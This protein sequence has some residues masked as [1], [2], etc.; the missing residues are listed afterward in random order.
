MLLVLTKEYIFA[1]H[2]FALMNCFRN[3]LLFGFLAIISTPL[4]AFSQLIPFEEGGKWGFMDETGNILVAAEYDNT[5]AK[6]GIG[7]C[8]SKGTNSEAQFY[9]YVIVD[10]EGNF[11]F[12]NSSCKLVDLWYSYN[13]GQYYAFSSNNQTVI[14][15]SKD[16]IIVPWGDY[17]VVRTDVADAIL[18]KK[19]GKFGVYNLKG[20]VVVNAQYSKENEALKYFVHSYIGLKTLEYDWVKPCAGKLIPVFKG[21]M[22]K[23]GRTK[24]GKWG[25]ADRQGKLVIPFEYTRVDTFIDGLARVNKGDKYSMIDYDGKPVVDFQKAAIYAIYGKYFLLES[26][27]DNNIHDIKI[28]DI[29]GRV[30]VEK[31]GSV[32]PIFDADYPELSKQYMLYSSDN[33]VDF[34]QSKGAGLLRINSGEEVIPAKYDYITYIGEGLFKAAIKCECD[35]ENASLGLC[36]V[37]ERGYTAS[38]KGCVFA[39]FDM[40]G[41]EV[42]SPQFTNV[43]S[44][45]NGKA[46]G[47]KDNQIFLISSEGKMMQPV[48]KIKQA[49]FSESATEIH[50]VFGGKSPMD[51]IFFDGSVLYKGTELYVFEDVVADAKREQYARRLSENVVAIHFSKNDVTYVNMNLR[52]VI[53]SKGKQPENLMNWVK[54]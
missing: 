2:L 31:K 43:S 22:D 36:T 27:T 9:N 24:T 6:E 3:A 13:R 34:Y 15:S 20:Q 12:E 5:T 28:Q 29:S 41:N 23:K 4:F 32:K 18:F 46:Y 47:F 7:I 16:N 26:Y 30:I 42:Y 45:K 10:G 11:L 17:T 50:T 40:K 54:G 38:S 51:V 37:E 48:K 8:R 21:E 52:K 14:I 35:Q 1:Q 49:G 39:I 33:N 44:F 25:F 19:Q 53:Y